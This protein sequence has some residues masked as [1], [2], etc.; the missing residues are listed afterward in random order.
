MIFNDVHKQILD[1][2]RPYYTT[3]QSN[4]TLNKCSSV[5][6]D[7]FVSVYKEAISNRKISLWC[8]ACIIEL[9][10]DCYKNYD[11]FLANEGKIDPPAGQK[12]TRQQSKL[13]KSQSQRKN[14][15]KS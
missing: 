5:I 12:P 11:K 10:E 9:I 14:V 6:I 2:N 1:K 15:Q 7:E 4:G 3:L 13:S 8:P